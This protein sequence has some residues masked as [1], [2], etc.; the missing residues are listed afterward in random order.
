LSS[1]NFVIFYYNLVLK[2]NQCSSYLSQK[3]KGR[4]SPQRP[5][6][7]FSKKQFLLFSYL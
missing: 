5:F 6:Y 1:Q 7:R 3:K 4:C 2:E